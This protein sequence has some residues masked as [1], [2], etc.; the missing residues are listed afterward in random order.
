VRV[1]DA[2]QKLAT[3]PRTQ[4]YRVALSVIPQDHW[5]A[6]REEHTAATMQ[7]ALS[8]MAEND[9]TADLVR[10]AVARMDPL[11]VKRLLQGEARTKKANLELY[12]ALLDAAVEAGDVP[13]GEFRRRVRAFEGVA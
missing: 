13:E 10:A 11:M 6:D 2:E 1:A 7:E 3:L 4:F 5:L 8:W 12:M 9:L